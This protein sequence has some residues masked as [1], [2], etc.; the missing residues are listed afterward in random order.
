M[1]KSYI[2]N[3]LSDRFFPLKKFNDN[4][5]DP[6]FLVLKQY[7][8]DIALQL[9]EVVSKDKYYVKAYTGNGRMPFVPW[10]GIHSSKEGFNSKPET[11]L[12]LTLLWQANGSGLCLSFQK[13]SDKS[14]KKQLLTTVEL[15]RES[16]D[17]S[18]FDSSIDL[19]APPKSKRP[20]NY[21]NAHIAGYTYNKFNLDK[22]ESDIERLESVYEQVIIDN[23]TIHLGSG[24]SEVAIINQK[25]YEPTFDRTVLDKRTK[26]LRSIK[27]RKKAVGNQKPSAKIVETTEYER[28]PAVKAE[29]LDRANGVCELCE[30]QAPFV[31]DDDEHFLEVHHIIQLSEGG[32]DI[33][34]NAIALCPNCHREAHYGKRRMMLKLLM[35]KKS[36]IF[37]K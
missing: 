29:V 2:L 6:D 34:K 35:Q 36:V 27:T 32:P 30:K 8:T 18:E 13:G 14:S 16:Y 21:Q 3:T 5:Q 4:Y 24:P 11:G 20:E 15:I 9:S 22:L 25:T 7:L 33:V 26:S 19:K 23:P 31:K 37:F 17:L 10:V 1:N 28:D 12:Y